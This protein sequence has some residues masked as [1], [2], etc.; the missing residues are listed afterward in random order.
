[1]VRKRKTMRSEIEKEAK[2]YVR[3]LSKIEESIINLG[4]I[5]TQPRVLESNFRYDTPDRSL[6]SSFQVLRLRQDSRAR[7]TYK[8]PSDP[9]SEVSARLEYEVDVSDIS[10]AR[11]I[12]EALGYE[13][14]TIYEKY[15][16][17]YLLDNAEISLD[18][19]PFGNFIEIEGSDVHQI[20]RV[21]EKISLEWKNRS[22]LSYLRIFSSLKERMGLSMRDLTFKNFSGI[23]VKPEHLEL[24]YAD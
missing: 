2:F 12:L 11:R 21:A 8:G 1:M 22:S 20:Q 16:T 9:R 15:R 10:V 19:M 17:S 5:N 4:S 23:D 6:S 24:Q 3:D 18:A 14:I 13:I 7:L